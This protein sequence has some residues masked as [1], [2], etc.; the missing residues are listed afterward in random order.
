MSNFLYRNLYVSVS[1]HVSI[2]SAFKKNLNYFISLH[3]YQIQFFYLIEVC[4]MIV[5]FNEN[6]F[7]RVK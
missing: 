7:L 6:V 1:F 4:S 2:E 5:T 3:Q